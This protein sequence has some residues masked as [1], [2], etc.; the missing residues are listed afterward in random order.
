M[1]INILL[2]WIGLQ[3]NAPVWFWGLLGA[4]VFINMITY[5]MKMHQKGA[6]K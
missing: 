1:I 2:F 3:L 4:K 5:G 6:G